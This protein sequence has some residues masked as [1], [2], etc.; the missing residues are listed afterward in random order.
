MI[1]LLRPGRQFG[2]DK[3]TAAINQA[4]ESGAIDTAAVRYL[5]EKDAHTEPSW[6]HLAVEE[7][8]RSEYY[9]RPIPQFDTYDRLLKG[10]FCSRGEQ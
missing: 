8:K 6:S 3:L 2:Y 5:M 4:S 10:A 7:V 1:E 9:T